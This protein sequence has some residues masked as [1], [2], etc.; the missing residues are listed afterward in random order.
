MQ[1]NNVHQMQQIDSK[2]AEQ[3]LEDGASASSLILN[4]QAFEQIEKLA[5]LMSQGKSTI[6]AHLRS[7]GDCMAV[8]MQAMQWKM[9][10]WSVAQ[11]TYLVNGVLGYE[12]QLVSAVIN[13]S[14]AV[15]SRFSFEFFG[16]WENVIG[17]FQIKNGDKGEYRIPGWR[18]EDEAG[19]GMSVS[20]TLKG[21]KEPRKLDLLLA[22]ARTRNSTLW[23]DDP[24]QQLA[25]LAQKKWARL[26][27]PDV[28]LGVYS[29]DELE[30]NSSIRDVEGEV[31]SQENASEALPEYPQELYE[32]NKSKY[33]DLITSGRPV[34]NII[35]KVES[36][37][38]MTEEQKTDLR[39]YATSPEND[40]ADS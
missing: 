14:G 7:T 36:K 34:E 15:T 11:K 37:Y 2:Q 24:K 29:A 8:I 16:P 28:I 5:T 35:N 20:A 1:D 22:Q 39:G 18:L 12:A 26:Y 33:V 9:N 17:K 3:I 38:T 19:I 23:A 27:A 6:P 21:E 30:D 25:Y 31:I 13:S 32:S 40:N 4:T 10:P